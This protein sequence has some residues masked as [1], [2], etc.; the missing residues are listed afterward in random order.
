MSKPLRLIDAID[1][2][3]TPST[4]NEQSLEYLAIILKTIAVKCGCDLYEEVGL[5]LE[6]KPTTQNQKPNGKRG[7]AMV[8]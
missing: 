1:R 3:A 6:K 8:M 2:F 5:R 7:G 4:P